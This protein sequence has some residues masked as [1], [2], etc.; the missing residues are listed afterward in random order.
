[1]S[2]PENPARIISHGYM[3]QTLDAFLYTTKE[4]PDNTV[5]ELNWLPWSN[6]PD[7]TY[8]PYQILLGRLREEFIIRAAFPHEAATFVR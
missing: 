3:G 2:L 6:R 1:M 4:E 7:G 5:V 8:G